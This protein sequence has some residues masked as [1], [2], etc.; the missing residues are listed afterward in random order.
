MT[1]QISFNLFEMNCVG[2]ISHGLWVHPENNRHRFNDLDFWV[3]TAQI[4]EA[5]LFDSVFLADVIGTYDGYRNGPDTALREAV[6]IP[7]NDPLLIIPA[8]AA[9]T[10]HLGFA[11]TFSTTYEP[12]FA[13]ARRASTLDH[14]TKGRFGWNIVTSYLP[15]A[16]RNFGLADEVEHDQ[17][18][19]IADE[20]L[21]VL[22]K[23]WE[24]SW[25]DDAVI[26]DRARRVY[27]DPAKVRYINHRGPNYSV[28]GPHLSSPSV[29]RTPVLFQA[30]SSTAGKEFA[31]KHAEGVFVG[32][33]DAAAYRENVQDLRRLA[34]AKGRQAD[35]IKA[36]ASAVVIVGRTH[37]EAQRKAEEYRRLSSAEGYLAHAGGGGID[38]AAYR[39]DE[40]IDDI[41]ARENR[42]G[43]D[44]Q[45]SSRRHPPGTT[46][47]EALE[48][49]TRFD[50]GPFVAI[51]TAVEVADEIERWIDATDLD[52]FNLRQFLT[53]GTA[54]DFITQVIPELQ[55]RGRYRTS[56]EEST[57][58]ER[59]FGSGNTRLFDE[60][61]GAR[62]RGGANLDHGAALD[63]ADSPAYAGS[64]S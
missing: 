59:L 19:A 25:D 10:K 34:V 47:G 54:E 18:Y 5:G 15:N 35:H 48:R 42:P 49:I 30:G 41:L 36:F 29:Q 26:E 61:P 3:E 64:R 17:R 45:P 24:G 14:L 16:A 63:L 39:S 52:G 20:Y 37:K 51:G 50:R 9:V 4:L 12:P 2:H 13:F 38:L 8:M 28:A 23:L 53:P 6:Q 33:R 32:G 62:Y 1:R 46:V 60:H 11:A 44:S 22:Y 55:R 31:A 56:Y 21:D 57:L 27:T 43:R 40:V 58:R 7:S